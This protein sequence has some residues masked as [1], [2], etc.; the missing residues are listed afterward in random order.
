MK[1]LETERLMLRTWNDNDVQPM[2]AINQD[3]KVMEYFPGLQDL[4]MTKNF[5]DKVNAHFE[6]HGYSLYTTVRKDTNEF[7]GFI[8]LLIADFKAHFTPATEIGWRLSSNHW[9]QG[10]ATEGAKAVLDYAFR[11]LKIPEIVSFT[12]AGNA[13]SIRVMQKIGLQHNE[14][15]DF[16]PPKLVDE[17]PLKRHVLY[18]LSREK[19]TQGERS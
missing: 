4:E 11:E 18:R 13:K 12:A 14:A 5:I 8:G 6:N 17:S 2:L 1:L 9:G 19:Y 16:D 15:D 3:P 7:I 10:F